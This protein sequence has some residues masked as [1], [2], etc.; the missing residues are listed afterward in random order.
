[1][2]AFVLAFVALLTTAASPQ[3]DP[4]SIAPADLMTKAAKVI[5]ELTPGTYVE[6]YT[7]TGSGEQVDGTRQISGDDYEVVER[8]GPF[9]YAWGQSGGQRWTQDENGTVLLASGF[10][11]KTNDEAQLGSADAGTRMHVLGLTPGG[12]DYVLDFLLTNGFHEKRYYSSQTYLLDRVELP[13]DDGRTH[14]WTLSDY[15]LISGKMVPFTEQYSDGQPENDTLTKVISFGPAPVKLAGVPQTRSLLPAA[16]TAPVPLPATVSDLDGIIVS[17]GVNGHPLKFI[18]DTGADGL[19]I[20]AGAAHAA[21]LTLHGRSK[22]S[23]AGD[24]DVSRTL[25]SDFTIGS[26][27]LR[28]VAFTIAPVNEQTESGRIQ[29]LLGASFFSSAIIGID[30][31]AKTAI[32][33]PPNA[34]PPNPGGLSVLPIDVDDGSP[35]ASASIEGVAGS[36]LVDTGGFGTL[37]Y[38]HYFDRLG[39]KTPFDESAQIRK[40]EFG[41]EFLGGHIDLQAYMVQDF[42]FG[43]VEFKQAAFLVPV[44]STANIADYDGIIGRDVLKYYTLYFDYAGRAIYLKPN[45]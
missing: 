5:G 33:Y 43:G 15:R 41:A 29:G 36:F 16:A 18:L 39:V 21:G 10:H 35:R 20:D 45:T 14:V 24:Y 27:H 12:A 40:E 2:R 25:V 34:S 4:A 38:R 17:V 30:F 23:I 7:S 13:A 8:S 22:A 9:T 1:M 11:Q 6:H 37:L 19:V 26:L 28:D 42:A 44:Q 31:K 3:Y 32:L